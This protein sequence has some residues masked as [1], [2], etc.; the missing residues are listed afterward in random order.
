LKIE[1]LVL[2]AWP[3]VEWIHRHQPGAERVAKLLTSARHGRIRLLMSEI[4][5]AEVY[6]YV[7]KIKPAGFAETWRSAQASFPIVFETPTRTEIWEAAELKA[8]YPI[9][10]ADAFAAALALKHDCPLI[11][12]DPEF[13]AVQ[14]IQLH[15]IG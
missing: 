8:R 15:W 4:N 2:D 1:S 7:R 3:M 6:Y 14:E 10:Y 12:G 9:S 5:S 13:R 11:T